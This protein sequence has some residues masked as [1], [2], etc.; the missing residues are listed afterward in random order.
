[1]E[2]LLSDLRYSG[3]VLRKN[4][5]FTLVAVL[6]IS[7]SIGATSAVF[8]VVNSVIL[9]PLSFREPEQLVRIWGKFE[10][11]GIPKNWISEPEL[12]DLNAACESYEAL[13]AFQTGGV[14]LT[15]GGEPARVNTASVNASFLPIL[16]INPVLGRTFTDEDDQPGRDNVVLISDRLWRSR[17]AA[18]PKVVG[19]SIGVDG[20]TLQVVGIMPAAFT[21]P[22][23]SDLWVPIAINRAAPNNRGNHGLEVVG[24]LKPGVSLEQAGAELET[25]AQTMREQY[26]NNYR[27]ESAFG[28]F[29]VRMQDEA[30]G[31]V[32]PALYVLLGAVL[33]VLLIACANVANL[34][35][36]R[37]TSREREIA[38]R[39]ALGARRLRLIR[40]LL[41]E[42]VLLA[43]IGGT[44]GLG[45]ALAGVR[46]FKAF[47][48]RDIPRLD[49]ISL[50]WRVVAF[51]LAITML[52]GLVFGLA[53]ALHASKPELHDALKEG[54]RGSTAARSK[55]RSALVLVEVALALVLLAGAGLM[56]QSFFKLLDFNLGYR[57]DR[58]LTMRLPLT[59]T[60]YDQA[61]QRVKFYRDVLD[62]IAILPGVEAAGAISH[63]PLSGSYG[64]GS[65][66]VEDPE[67]S[68]GLPRFNGYPYIEADRRIA[69]ADYFAALGI[70]LRKGRVFTRADHET[71]PR[72][73]V[74]DESFERRFWPN[75]SALG[76][77]ILVGFDQPTN[78]IRWGEIVGVVAH[79]NHYGIDQVKDYGLKF[80]GREQV[81]Y[82]IDQVTPRQM[83]FA[84]RTSTDPSSLASAVRAQVL[85]L[86]AEQPIYQVRT[87]DELFTTSVS[88]RRLNMFLFVGFSGVALVLSAVGIYGVLSYSVTQ[89]TH[90][91]GIRMALG[92]K[93][94]SV[95]GLVVRQGMTLV[96]VGLAAGVGAAVALTRLM[97]SLLFNVS[98]TDPITLATM[99]L[100]L[101]AVALFACLIPARRAARVDPMVALRYE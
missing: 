53:P 7:I 68:D 79:I 48:P 49:E 98:P 30:V 57:T 101:T 71:A 41:T 4:P 94:A 84:I 93:Q 92:A 15:S 14:N 63:L 50:D 47:A 16:G 12:L 20:A 42:S 72:V 24:R 36:A 6:A 23:D 83:F 82:P 21:F 45:L 52:T 5:A 22:E 70:P 46:V 43:L 51:S 96:V 86:D 29:L 38:V 1:M 32:K 80:E 9:K 75:G 65:T 13:A 37:S 18:D 60:R 81:Y 28:L 97:Q 26:P 61:P 27:A 34:L 17:F 56:I 19:S 54:A 88:Q 99:A 100:T 87:M 77:R 90:E 64:S 59:S 62:R 40:Q 91:I 78:T 95:L 35:L 66:T 33:F 44:V 10:G 74:V 67:V 31:S 11:D 58:T 69:S 3:R 76:K 2:N 73:L 25:V 39:A 8:S 89:R 85:G 55:L